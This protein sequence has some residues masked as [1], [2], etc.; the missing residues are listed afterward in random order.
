MAQFEPGYSS[1]PGMASRE[2]AAARRL[3]ASGSWSPLGSSNFAGRLACC[4]QEQAVGLADSSPVAGSSHTSRPNSSM[5]SP[6]RLVVADRVVAL[7]TEFAGSFAVVAN[8]PMVVLA[9]TSLQLELSALAPELAHTQL[10]VT[11][12]APDTLAAFLGKQVA[13]G[14]AQAVDRSGSGVVVVDLRT[15]ACMEN[16][17]RYSPRRLRT[18]HPLPNRSHLAAMSVGGILVSLGNNYPIGRSLGM[19]QLTIMVSVFSSARDV[20]AAM[21]NKPKRTK[22]LNL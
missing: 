13:L 20:A 15:L 12:A 2:L 4:R 14:R 5:G 16:L 9:R 22:M 21:A 8:R 17:S 10:V 7:G 18:R 3:M 1:T 19:F 11:V 6:G